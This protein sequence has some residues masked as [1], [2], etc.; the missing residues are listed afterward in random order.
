MNLWVVFFIAISLSMDAFSLAISLGTLSIPLQSRI[1]LSFIV[2][3]FHFFAPLFGCICSFVILNTTHLDTHL[4]SGIIFL[5]IA[6]QMLKDFKEKGQI[7]LSE[8]IVG[9]LFFAMGV[10]LDSFGV[11]MT[12][13]LSYNII[14]YLF[15]FAFFSGMFTFLGLFL[16][17]ITHK[18]LGKFSIIMGA[19]IMIVLSIVNFVKFCCF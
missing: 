4:L 9:F 13:S 14:L 10:S 7:N 16:G 18:L 15:I 1:K 6:I 11:G 2:G 19:C 12:L 17:D 8:S 5:Y 3:L